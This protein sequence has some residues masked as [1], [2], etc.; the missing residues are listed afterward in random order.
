MTH[1]LGSRRI[2]AAVESCL[3]RIG[4]WDCLEGRLLIYAERIRLRMVQYA[5]VVAVRLLTLDRL[6]S[7]RVFPSCL[8]LCL[9]LF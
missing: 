1:H 5:D 6:L 3:H 4:R 9:H 2:G 7:F 8:I